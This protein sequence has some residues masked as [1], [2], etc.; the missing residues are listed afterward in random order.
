M[1][2]A[3]ALPRLGYSREEAAQI[4]GV[5]LDTIRR[6]INKGTLRAKRT[7]ANGGGKYLITEQAIRDW[8]ET[9]DDA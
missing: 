7:G 6:A 8:L 1:L 4:C 3:A 2:S 5:S 9:L